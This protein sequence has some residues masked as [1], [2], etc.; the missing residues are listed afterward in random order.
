[1]L[2]LAGDIIEE[3]KSGCLSMIII[4]IVIATGAVIL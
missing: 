2:T 4:L 1:M 3:P